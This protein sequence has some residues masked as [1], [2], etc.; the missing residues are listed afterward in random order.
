MRVEQIENQLIIRETPGCIW[1]FSSLFLVVG[2][3]FVYGSLGNFTNYSTVPF[4]LIPITFLMGATG[5]GVGIRFIYNA[6][7]TKIN[8]NRDSE[9]LDYTTYGIA[10]RTNRVYHF[11]EIEEFCLI[12]GID[13]ESNPIWSLGME[14]KGGET[15][16]ISSLESHDE[17]FKRDFVFRINEF[18]Y[19]QMPSAQTVFELEDESAD[20]MS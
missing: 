1:I 9:T 19:K 8:I 11:D 2:G 20:E 15:I 6:P 10:G 13:D 12:E 4:W 5:C 16:K 7:I 18:M 14:L 3:L 17:L